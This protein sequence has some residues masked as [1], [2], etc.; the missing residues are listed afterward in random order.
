MSLM[1]G[2]LLL[3]WEPGGASF[4]SGALFIASACLC[5]AIDNNLT[6][7]V[8]TNDAMLI[9]A[10]K[11]LLAGIGNT[12]LALLGGAAWPPLETL[13]ATLV[14]GFMEHGLMPDAVRTGAANARYIENGRLFFRGPA[15]RR[16]PL[17]LAIWPAMP[18]R[19]FWT[20]GLLMALGVWLH[21]R[22]RHAHEHTHEPLMHSHRHS[23]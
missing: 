20:A 22:E 1:L 23:H 21:V 9:A 10:L 16:H 7:K 13:G 17:S 11:G 8:S 18:E 6:R 3:S 4:S 2:G 15:V 12:A 5:W 19:P 14:I